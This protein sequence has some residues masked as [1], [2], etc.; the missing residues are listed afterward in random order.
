MTRRELMGGVAGALFAAPA[1]QLPN[2]ILMMADDQGWGDTGYNGHPYLKTPN[3]DAMAAAGLR[4][5]R[6]YSGAPVCSPT[7]GSALTGRHPF[8][9]GIRFANVGHM[10]PDEVTL[11]EAL[12]SAGYTTGHFG[13]WHLGTLSK[14]VKDGRRGGRDP[15][16]YAPPWEHGFDVSF[17][18]EQAVPTWDPMKDQPFLTKYWTGPDEYAQTNLEGDDSRAIMDRALPFISDALRRKK[19]FFAVIWFH[20]PH[21]PVRAGDKY[22]AM[23][24][25]HSEGEQHFYGTI[26]ALDEQVGRLRAELRRLGVSENTMVWYC[27]DNGPEGKS[28]FAGRTRG[29]AGGLRGRKRS[30]FEGGI[31][32]PGLLEWPARIRQPRRTAVPCVT[33]DYLP[34]ILEATGLP[35]KARVIDG[36][37]LMPLIEGRVK[38]RPRNIA[39]ET[40]GQAE[41]RLGS[42]P[43]ALIGNRYKLL[44]ALDESNDMLFDLVADPGERHDI[45]AEKPEIVRAMRD[46]LSKWR[47][48]CHASEAGRD[49]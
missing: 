8:R 20:A 29:S 1:Q 12:R 37:S 41:E 40:T 13:K 35:R 11:A 43:L 24:K 16:E 9:Y 33:S 21:E 23:Y 39:F 4:F 30:L 6:F 19:P 25:E 44:S 22:R 48:S 34:T 14:T 46:E 3:L 32:V 18:T 7:R 2:V 5:D 31:R 36:I 26:T 17:S 10:R 15:K 28:P 42:P 47:E 45:S 49:Y 38:E 27:S